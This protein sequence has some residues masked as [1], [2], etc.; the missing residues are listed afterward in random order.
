[1]VICGVCNLA[2][3]IRVEVINAELLVGNSISSLLVV[4][5]ITQRLHAGNLQK[6]FMGMCSIDII[7]QSEVVDLLKGW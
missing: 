2:E 4:E 6:L 7:I 3:G 1:M 5:W